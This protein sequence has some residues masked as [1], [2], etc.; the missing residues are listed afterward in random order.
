MRNLSFGDTGP[1]VQLLQLALGRAGYGPLE[2]DGIFGLA[3]RAALIRFQ[4]DHR[5]LPDGIAGRQTHH[6]LQPWYTGFFRHTVRPGESFW[7]IARLY[8]AQTEAVVAANPAYPPEKLPIGSQV[9]VPLPF[10]VVPTDIAYCAVLVAYCVRGLTARY[11]FL[12]SESIGRSVLGKP[13]WS[14]HLGQGENRV[15]YNAAHH[16]NE[17][18]TTPL[19]LRF[20]EELCAAFSTGGKLFDSPAAELLEYARLSLVPCVNPD[21]MDL[22]TGELQSGDAYRRAEDLA[23]AYPRFPFP[24]GWK[25]NIRGTDLNL[26]YPAGW[27]KARENKAAQGISSPAPADYVGPAPLSAP[28]SR[29]MFDYTLRF[30]PALTLSYHSQGQVIYWRYLDREPEGAEAI[31]QLFSRVSGYAVE[32]VPYASGF[33]GYKDWF[34]QDFDRPGYTIEVGLGENPLPLSQFEEIYRRN[35][36]ILVLGMIAT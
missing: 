9:T 19:L 21:G 22:V 13:L 14:L 10:P 27:E 11:P 35:L 15:L 29:A 16:A 34:I 24:S 1:A 8:G 23:A 4:T 31:A 33:A 26:Q 6:A 36:G 2:R 20:T 12:R 30:D 17:W 28:E 32:D 5:L 18:I 3:T 7:S 25:A